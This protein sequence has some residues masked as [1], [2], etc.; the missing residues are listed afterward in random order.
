MR[1]RE[2]NTAPCPYCGTASPLLWQSTNGYR[3]QPGPAGAQWGDTAGGAGAAGSA[4]PA[5]QW[6]YR[7]PQLSFDTPI[8]PAAPTPSPPPTPS[9]QQPI[10]FSYT[11]SAVPATPPQTPDASVLPPGQ[12]QSFLPVPY[13]QPGWPMPQE[14]RQPTLSLQLVP[15]HMVQHLVPLQPEK[16]ESSY[17]PPFYTKPRPIIPRYRVFSGLLSV[18][19]VTLLL[20]GG[21]G[22]YAKATGKLDAVTHFFTGPAPASLK[23]KAAPTLPDPPDQVDKGPAYDTVPSATTASHV[24]EKN[25]IALQPDKIFKVNQT[26][27]VICTVLAPKGD[28]KVSF[29]WYTNKFLFRT[30]AADAKGQTLNVKSGDIKSLVGSM[31]YQQPAE[32]S[33]E[34]YWNNNLAQRLYFVVR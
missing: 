24:D 5:E 2:E 13:Q 18:L 14:G 1:A 8:S 9:W 29:K 33:V 26:F 21:A 32:G 12:Q 25:A 34:I 27:Y 3:E 15:E 16:Q 17:I 28:G 22:Y 7:I 19:L 6:E 4:A 31:S 20:C 30:I 11:E 10:S 23:P